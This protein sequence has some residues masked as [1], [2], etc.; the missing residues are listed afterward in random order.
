MKLNFPSLPHSSTLM[1]WKAKEC[2]NIFPNSRNV[3]AEADII[4]AVT[5]KLPNLGVTLL[6]V[7][8]RQI[9]DPMEI[10]K[11]AITSQP[12]AYLHV[13]E[14]IEISKLLGL[15]SHDDISS[16]QEALAREAAVAGDLQL[17]FDLCLVLARKGHGSVWDLCAALARGPALENTDVSS[18]KQLLGF[19]L[20]HCDGESIG[21][22]LNAWKDLDLQGQCDALTALTGKE[23][24]SILNY[25]PE[26]S[27]GIVGM[28]DWAVESN[29]NDI[30]TN[31]QGAQIEKI[32]KMLSQV[33]KHPSS[34]HTNDLHSLLRENAKLSTFAS[35]VLPWLM[36]LSRDAD[37]GQK[38]IPISASGKQH[39]SARTQAVVAILSWL[40][41]SGFAPTDDFIATLA[42]SVMEPP[43]TE[44]EDLLGCSYLLNLE[45]ALHGVEVIEE[46]VRT[47]EKYNEISSIMDLGVLYSFLHSCEA[48]SKD[49]DQKRELLL[50]TFQQRNN[51]IN[52]D[53]GSKLD[54]AQSTFWRDWKLKLEEQKR[55]AEQSKV[56]EQIIPG[57]DAG[58]F[59]SRDR[60]YINSVLSSQIES[61]RVEKKAILKNVIN[62]ADSYG[63]NRSMVLLHYVSCILV[64][65]IWTI[66]DVIT[67]ISDFREEICA[68]TADSIKVLSSVYAEID[69]LD[70]QRLA[71]IYGLLSDC[72][73]CL[74]EKQKSESILG[75][76]FENLDN[77][78]LAHF[79]KTVGEECSRVSFIKDLNFKNIAGMNGLNFDSFNNEVLAHIN[80]TNVEALAQMVQSLLG[81]LGVPN[82]KG[83]LSGQYVYTHHVKS[84]LT[85]LEMRASSEIH[86]QVPEDLLYFIREI[87]NTYNNCR[88]FFR[89][90]E[91][92]GLWKE[93]TRFFSIISRVDESWRGLS[94]DAIWHDCLVALL[95]FWVKLM[96]DILEFEMD[97]SLDD[98]F[99][100]K[101]PITCVKSFLSLVISGKISTGQGWATVF[102][103]INNGL[104]GDL[105]VEVFNFCRAMILSGCQFDSVATVF[106]EAVPSGSG[107]SEFNQNNDIQGLCHLYLRILE[108]IL[109]ESSGGSIRTETLHNF[110]SSLRKLEGDLE[111]LRNV[112]LAVWEK[113]AEFSENLQIPSHTR[114]QVLE[115]MQYIADSD[116][117]RK[118]MFPVAHS[119][120]TPWEGWEDLQYTNASQKNST[121]DGLEDAAAD[122][123]NRFTNTLIALKSSQLVST[124]SRSLEITP[125]DLSSVESAVSCFHEVS[126]VALSESHIGS[127]RAMLKEWENLFTSRETETGSNNLADVESNW[128]N[129]D[130]DNEGWEDFQEEPVE[131]ETTEDSALSVHPLHACWALFFRKVIIMSQFEGLINLVDKSKA[132]TSQ[133]LLDEDDVS[134]LSQT[135][136]ELDCFL[137]VKFALLFPYEAVQ[138]QCLDACENKLK[139]E[140]MSDKIGEDRQLFPLVLSSGI[141]SAIITRPS[142]NTTFS[143]LCYL[144]GNFS[145]QCQE[146]LLSSHKH[147][148]SEDGES[149]AKNFVYLFTRVLFPCFLAELVK[150]DQQILAAFLL[151]K[152][153]HTNASLSLISVA[154]VSLRKYLERQ[155]EMVQNDE[156]MLDETNCGSIL[157]TL[158]GLRLRLGSLLRSSLSLLTADV[159]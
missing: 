91:S 23:P 39:I 113:L 70:K 55:V 121:K 42:R 71:F 18:R 35:L 37:C 59:I 133:T 62:L 5:V 21:E 36:E 3:R 6:P 120:V 87:E 44:E 60:E 148:I 17:S 96:S 128:N 81:A 26:I 15:S 95:D 144:V 154:D 108:S 8:F 145:R 159:R 14:L 114:V 140:G 125:E 101:C 78:G 88:R 64:S 155:V 118:G 25:S 73:L 157:N 56:L 136:L 61:V 123:T 119:D 117:Q 137:A 135:L 84:M 82:S 147:G 97:G 153:M 92:P 100:S 138:L 19:A 131:K 45:D 33:A 149:G 12:G 98:K 72:Y 57:V 43:V 27:E 76:N 124:I 106:S 40:A 107:I 63:L 105:D 75:Q 85:V 66:E 79:H 94:H 49:P 38:S 86:P 31:N 129:D 46:H 112:R 54:E 7:Q 16:V 103:Y 158:S 89:L 90:M 22:L 4:E 50:K 67:E 126:E 83:I 29:L 48:E 116:R 10:I 52:S 11:L 146:T 115:L 151:T 28:S 102:G 152:Y 41:R 30:D 51:P 74:E 47:R 110:M 141:V 150:A 9:K 34:D 13:D 109:Q 68:C 80:E 134:S 132:Q 104:M 143:C 2:L 142:Y 99:S 24:S 156:I 127:L 77:I 65:E 139:R 58:R 130:W 111:N 122:G 93:M 20:S 53:D 32:K 69:G 1:I